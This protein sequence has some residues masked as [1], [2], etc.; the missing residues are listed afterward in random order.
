[1]HA[2]CISVFEIIE[3]LTFQE[4]LD[5]LQRKYSHA[6]RKISELKRHESFLAVQL[7][8]R[9]HEYHSHLARLR[10]R[11]V[12]LE[13][14]LAS[15]QQFAGINAA[16]YNNNKSFENSNL[17][18]PELLKQPPVRSK[19]FLYALSICPAQTGAGFNGRTNNLIFVLRHVQTTKK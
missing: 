12:H 16:S 13:R 5:V 7:Q 19:P 17:S 2:A 8:E 18:P 14:E 11:V 4:D 15:A 3:R 6:K 10:D 9:D 1:M